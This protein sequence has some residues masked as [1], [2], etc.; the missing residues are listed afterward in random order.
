ML[1]SACCAALT[2]L[3]RNDHNSQ[4]IV[5]HN[6]VYAIS[7][8]I[9]P[10]SKRSKPTETLQKNALRTL[11]FLFSKEGNRRMFQRIF[12][13]NNS[14]FTAFI[15]VGH[16]V[17][18]IEKYQMVVDRINNLP[19][20]ELADLRESIESSNQQREP[21]QFIEDYAVLEHLG[22]GAFGSVCKVRKRDQGQS[23]YAL[24]E[25]NM[26]MIGKNNK[27]RDKSVGEI[28]SEINIIRDQLKHPNI[29]K[30]YRTFTVDTTKLCIVMEL[31]DGA[32]LGE[33][34]TSLKE[35]KEA[36][37]EARI[38]NIYI[39]IVLALRYL[40]KE[41]HIV[42]R[43]LTPNNIMLSENDKVTITDFGLAK[44]KADTQYLKSTVGT[45]LYSCPEIVQDHPYGEKADIWAIGCILYQ[46]CTLSPPFITNNMLALASRIVAG[47]Y[48]PLQQDSYST[49][50]SQTIAKCLTVNPRERPD[51]VGVAGFIAEEI[52]LHL[53]S[54]RHRQFTLERKLEK[55]RKRTQ[56]NHSK[57]NNYM[58][59]Y[60][61]LFIASQERYDKLA[62]S[63]TSLTGSSH[64]N[65]GYLLD[66]NNNLGQGGAS[67]DDEEEPSSS[68]SSGSA[69]S[70][71]A[72]FSRPPKPPPSAARRR[73]L[74]FNNNLEVEIPGPA[75]NGRHGARD[76]GCSSAGEPSP[77]HDSLRNSHMYLRSLSSPV[78]D[79]RNRERSGSKGRPVS[80]GNGAPTLSISPRKV[81]QIS[82]PIQQ[83]LNVLHKV[84][85]ITQLPPTLSHNPRR[86]I[87]DKFKRA[88][89]LPNTNPA[90]LKTE[91]KKLAGGSPD[92]IDIN[93]GNV[94]LNE[95]VERTS[96]SG[97]IDHDSGLEGDISHGISYAQ[98]N[99]IIERVLR[100]QDYY[101]MAQKPPQ[102]RQRVTSPLA[103]ISQSNYRR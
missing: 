48:E 38:W 2:E 19:E 83:I 33:H 13:R 76:S 70:L 101:S 26:T 102:P 27:D 42:H 99:T 30:Y 14:V 37:T 35:K 60:Q 62:Q 103:A 51:I 12:R 84:I 85:Y 74:D 97:A 86:T 68:D 23:L 56:R 25:V 1:K 67:G 95:P 89:F 4:Q 69:A 46:M 3:I 75:V 50:V 78:V 57:A 31:I 9:I 36:F 22:S 91:L 47:K 92:L 32:P 44:Q 24:K 54:L 98:L 28:I 64:L 79:K 65:Q 55:E 90:H 29:V 21:T 5:A 52:M 20:T 61:K 53:E 82:D 15:D 77:N 59:S 66:Q 94:E 17:H 81:R 58:Q 41:K 93:F 96:S 11:R 10:D 100:E 34:F 88:L 18:T 7:K 80:T 6:G 63:Q 45:I 8:L 49:K 72:G 71:R 87:I 40:H 39:Q 43:D 16:Y 73:K